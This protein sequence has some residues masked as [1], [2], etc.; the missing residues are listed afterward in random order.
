MWIDFDSIFTT[1]DITGTDFWLAQIVETAAP[2]TALPLNLDGP[3]NI[4][5][6]A[7]L[8]VELSFILQNDV[9]GDDTLEIDNITITQTEAVAPAPGVIW[10][11]SSGLLGLGV[12]RRK[13]FV[14]RK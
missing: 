11:L 7:G 8:N 6:F 5:A 1:A 2:Y 3:S 9:G 14:G 4:T 12:A 13:Q 10:L